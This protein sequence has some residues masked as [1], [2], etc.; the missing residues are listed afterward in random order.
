MDFSSHPLTPDTLFIVLGNQL[1][2]PAWLGDRVSQNVFFMAEDRGLCTY[3]RHHQQ[4]LLLFL[5]AMRSYAEELGERGAD[6]HYER[7]ED[8]GPGPL[9]ASYEVKLERFIRGKGFTRLVMWEVEDHFFETRIGAFADAQGLELE[10]LPSPMFVTPRE[11]FEAYLEDANDRPGGRIQ[12]AKFYQWQRRRLDVLMDDGGPVGGHWSFDQD[13]RKKL[14]KKQAVPQTAWATPTR[15][16]ADVRA[17]IAKHFADH[18]GT[19]PEG[20][21]FWL[22]TTR[23]QALQWLQAFLNER[24]ALF[25]PYEDALSGRDPV[26]FHSVLSPMMNLGLLTPD[27]IVKRAV[28]HAR[29]CGTAMNSLEGFVRQVIG[30]RE[31][32]RGVY[33]RHD[34]EQSS[35]NFFGHERTLK[36][37]WYDGTTGLPPLDDAITKA[38]DLGWQ[39]HIERLMVMGNLMTLA[40]IHPHDAHRWFMEMFVDSSDWVM[41]P[42]VYGM[43][44]FSDG[45]MFA[46]KPYICGSNYLIKMSD[47]YKKGEPWCDVVDGLYWGF[48]DRNRGFF[49][50]NH[51]L[52]MMPRSLDKLEAGRKARIFAAADQ[53]A[54]EVTG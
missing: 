51:R 52:S 11:A 48:V 8:Q 53:W 2:P 17:V 29:E 10:F 7:F 41:G 45:G 42:N 40:Q 16:V 34:Q 22:P 46:T 47:H 28:E 38:R 37:C 6:L 3:V 1:F 19:L 20:G 13:N 33:H 50:G 18:P 4:K 31:F 54:D 12:L 39:H 5:A 49:E 30:W 23:G 25:G 36:P 32:V 27:E 14:P 15:H 35:R 43:G 26:L 9:Q 24:F 21:A 44:L